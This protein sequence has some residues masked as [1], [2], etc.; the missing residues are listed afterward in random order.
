MTSTS[1]KDV[2]LKKERKKKSLAQD[3]QI[4]IRARSSDKKFEGRV[5]SGSLVTSQHETAKAPRC[6]LFSYVS[7]PRALSEGW[8]WPEENNQSGPARPTAEL[9]ALRAGS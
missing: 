9:A 6:C 1:K 5:R 8:A 3:K 7:E 2:D 4:E